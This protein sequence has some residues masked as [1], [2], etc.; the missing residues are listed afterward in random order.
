[1]RRANRRDCGVTFSLGF[2][3]CVVTVGWEIG[4]DEFFPPCLASM[5]VKFVLT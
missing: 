2:F 3:E 4:C 5:I 1:M